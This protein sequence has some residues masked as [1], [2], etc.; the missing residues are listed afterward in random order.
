MRDPA[1]PLALPDLSSG[2]PGAQALREEEPPAVRP[3]AEPGP[4]S[5]AAAAAHVETGETLVAEVADPGAEDGA[6]A[7]L[8]V[9]EPWQRY[10]ALSA[11]DVIDRLGAQDPAALSVLLLYERSHRA[12]KTVLDAAERE[13]ARRA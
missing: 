13:L 1:P 10:D 9:E 11:A 3:V 2:G 7:E 6:G 4:A 8:H 12:R 5:N